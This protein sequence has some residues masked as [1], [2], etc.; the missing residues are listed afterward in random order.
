[1]KNF[2]L[3]LILVLTL[4]GMANGQWQKDKNYAGVNIGLSGV[5]S[6]I[7]FGADY[8]RAVYDLSGGVGSIGVGA[9]FNYWTYNFDVLAGTSGFSYRYLTFGLTGSF[10][11]QL[12]D[13]KWDPFAGLVLGYYVVN[14]TTPAGTFNF[15]FEGSRAYLGLQGGIRYFFSPNIAAQARVGFG[16]YILAVG[17]DFKF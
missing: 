12:P 11:F 10:H 15:G 7:T 16:A 14:V 2:L 3:T 4:A 9:L 13:K 17:V 6:T 1:M 5:G 8:E